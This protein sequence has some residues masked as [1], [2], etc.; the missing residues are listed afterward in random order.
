MRQPF[1]YAGKN[2]WY[3]WIGDKKV[4]L[5]VR[6]EG[7]EEEAFKAWHKLMA[8][9]KP[10]PEPR[11]GAT[12][13]AV[14][15]GFLADVESRVSPGCLRN[16]RLFL[17]PFA[18]RYGSR[19]AEA[20]TVAE[21]EAYSRKS[22]WSLSYRNGFIG[23]LVSAYRW[24]E[25]GQLLS[26][27]PLVGIRKPA[28]ASR[29]TKALISADE[30]ARLVA[31]ADP[32]FGAYLQLLWFTGARPGEIAGLRAEEIDHAQGVVVLT[33]HKEAHL[34]KNRI[35]FLCP[36]A[37]A[38]LRRLDVNEG[39]FS[40]AKMGNGSRLKPSAD[41]LLGSAKRQGSRRAWPTDT[42]TAS[43]PTPWRTA[44]LMPK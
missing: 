36:E 9:G 25:R 26:R 34:G 27:N 1:F 19:P 15:D 31:H 28:K 39:L 5:G 4:S 16:Y 13:K 24:A 18:K 42:G 2:T 37:L 22:Q 23:S 21:A 44:F 10:T 41:G 29:G 30:H 40:L 43:Q 32:L 17:L 3:V 8:N 6:G 14:I 7:N 12:V 11:A 33:N 20:L 35:L 38:V